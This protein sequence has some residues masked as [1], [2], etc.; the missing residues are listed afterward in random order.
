MKKSVAIIV[1]KC[2]L[3]DAIKSFMNRLRVWQMM[4]ESEW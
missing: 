2:A 4:P 3:F 1:Y